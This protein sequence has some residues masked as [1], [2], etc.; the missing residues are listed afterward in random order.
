MP[1]SVNK[2]AHQTC[3][4][5]L[6]CECMCVQHC[7]R[8]SIVKPRSPSTTVSIRSIRS[9]NIY[10]CFANISITYYYIY[11]KPHH[12][13]EI[14][15]SFNNTNI[16]ITYY[17]IYNKPHHLKEITDSF[18]NTNISFRFL[19]EKYF[20]IHLIVAYELLTQYQQDNVTIYLQCLFDLQTQCSN[21]E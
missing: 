3:F 17:Y 19:H 11:N 13:K 16:S 9:H 14:T 15:D 7:V 10:Q 18:N 20:K 4:F 21:V 8:I 1:Q 5:L 2:F 6:I 12:L